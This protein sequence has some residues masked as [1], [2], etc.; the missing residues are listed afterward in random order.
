M[1]VSV[2]ISAK[3]R[4]HVL[5]TESLP[6]DVEDVVVATEPGPSHARNA[7]IRRAEHDVLVLLDDDLRFETSWFEQFAGKVA[8]HPER[9]YAARGDGLL[10]TVEWPDGFDP[11]MT[12]VM[13]FHRRAWQDVGGFKQPDY[14]AEDPDYGSDTDFLMSAYERGYVV[15]AIDHEWHHEDEVDEYTTLQNARWLYW[16]LTRHPRLVAPKILQLIKNGL[17]G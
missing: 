12:R 3:S 9:V 14:I 7:G 5:S 6:D 15:D 11:G 1:D 4:E 10:T 2:V 8:D 13:G 16:L 17:L